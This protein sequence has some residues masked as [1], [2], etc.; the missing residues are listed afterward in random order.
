MMEKE[1]GACILDDGATVKALDYLF[2]GFLLL[3]SVV[4]LFAVL[5]SSYLTQENKVGAKFTAFQP[6]HSTTATW[7][8]LKH[9]PYPNYLVCSICSSIL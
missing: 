8:Q 9:S 3:L 5:T 7:R 6:V 1:K 4:L 2:P